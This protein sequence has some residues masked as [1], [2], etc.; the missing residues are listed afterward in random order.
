MLA[1]EELI[2]KHKKKLNL[3][4]D[5]DIFNDDEVTEL[6]SYLQNNPLNFCVLLV[7]AEN[8]KAAI[9]RPTNTEAD[10]LR[11]Q[12]TAERNVGKMLTA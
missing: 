9:T 8:V 12:E 3:A 6:T 11:L 5:P 10:Y 1:A 2:A 7:D 4:E